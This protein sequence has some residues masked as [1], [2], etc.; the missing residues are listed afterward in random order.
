[1]YVG[2]LTFFRGYSGTLKAGTYVKNTV[3]N[4]RERIG[5][6][7]QMHA[8]SR[9]EISTIYSGEI[10][11][12]IDLRDTGT[13]DTL[14]DDNHPVILASMDR[15]EPVLSVAIEPKTKAGQEKMGE[16][17]G[18]LAE[19]DPTFGTETDEETGQTIISGMGELH[20]DIIVDR[21]KREF[22]V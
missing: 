22:K 13:D 11:A 9:E 21:L 12:A 7:L 8:N 16:A 2:K 14:C 10:A 6:I 20:V 3:K 15:P 5:R 19:E 1:P 4:K 17:V 18:K